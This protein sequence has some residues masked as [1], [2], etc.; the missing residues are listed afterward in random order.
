MKQGNLI[1]N[2]LAIAFAAGLFFQC[3]IAVRAAPG[4]PDYTFGFLGVKI[5]ND[6][7]Y[8]MNPTIIAQQSDGKLL[9]AGSYNTQA[10][11]AQ[12]VLLRRY[13]TNGSVDGSFGLSGFAVA[14]LF[15]PSIVS[16]YGSGADLLV[17][18]DGKIVIGGHSPSGATI[19]RFNPNGEL[20]KTFSG[21]GMITVQSIPANPVKI[22]SYQ[23]K[24]IVALRNASAQTS[25]LIRLNTNGSLDSTFGIF[26][27]ISITIDNGYLPL[28]INPSNGKIIVGGSQYPTPALQHF[29]SNGTY[30]TA[31]GS[32]G[33]KL[34][35]LSADCGT[36]TMTP[37]WFYSLAPQSDGTLIA[38][39]GVDTIGG[40]TAASCYGNAIVRL[41]ADDTLDTGYGSGGFAVKCDGRVGGPKIKLAANGLNH[42]LAKLG[43]PITGSS[44]HFRRYN[45]AGFQDIVFTNENPVDFLGQQAD[46]KIV[47]V[48]GTNGDIRLARY[49]P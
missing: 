16:I 9:V 45:S 43:A 42:I 33:I 22:V 4:G 7:I 49:L 21:D 19:W 26:G 37:R 47:T 34:V 13:N 31:F 44:S 36:Y 18:S 5:D 39:A 29:N 20:D 35:P 10:N 25:R 38:G 28:V 11:T 15:N 23:G 3:E 27:Q 46:G 24:Y 48:S 14:Q 17:Q 2:F 6:E 1:N 12:R 41:N 32:N 8:N 30:D 40:C